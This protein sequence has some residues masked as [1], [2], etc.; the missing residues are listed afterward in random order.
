MKDLKVI[1]KKL[2]TKKSAGLDGLTQEQLKA[3]VSSL[4]S[5]LQNV[6]NH[7]ISTGEFPNNWNEAIVTPVHKKGDKSELL[8]LLL[9]FKE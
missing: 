4:D 6:F 2:K 8:L 1:I 9:L 3:G 5:P 7:S